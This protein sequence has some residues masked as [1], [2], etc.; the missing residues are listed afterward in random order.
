MKSNEGQIAILNPYEASKFCDEGIR[1]RFAI[2]EKILKNRSQ[3]HSVGTF[4]QELEDTIRLRFLQSLKNPGVRSAI[5]LRI[6][7][8]KLLVESSLAHCSNMSKLPI[9]EETKE[10]LIKLAQEIVILSYLSEFFR[11]CRYKV[12]DIPEPLLIV[13]E[14][15]GECGLII[16]GEII[17]SQIR[18][19]I[20][21]YL[22][23]SSS[24]I[25]A[26]EKEEVSTFEELV[27]IIYKDELKDAF[28][29]RFGINIR[30]AVK[31]TEYIARTAEGLKVEPLGRFK[32]VIER[33]LRIPE[34]KIKKVIEL[35]EC[36]K[37]YLESVFGEEKGHYKLFNNPF[38]LLRKPF[39]KLKHGGKRYIVYGPYTVLYALV[40]FLSDI[41]RG[42]I[43]L[44]EVS[45]KLREKYGKLFEQKLREILQKHGLTVLHPKKIPPGEIDALIYDEQK[46]LAVV[47]EAK[48]HRT[49]VS[50]RDLW[51]QI[52]KENE[53]WVKKLERKL[54]WI[55][56]HHR[57]L[58]LH[59]VEKVHGVIVT[60]GPLYAYTSEKDIEIITF[61]Q[62]PEVLEKVGINVPEAL[63]KELFLD[64]S[65]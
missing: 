11:Y 45:N 20:S 16:P 43:P 36:K 17:A 53:E 27:E 65:V 39:V 18:M 19:H 58:N 10:Q 37:E 62:L 26:I 7:A 63:K 2:L 3:F 34:N 24:K 56:Q 23:E 51:F 61:V 41:D 13:D 52:K 50:P 48:A 25:R 55:Q 38:S 31:F 21:A 32:R 4:Y 30:D 22:L 40:V 49:D 42:F 33:N 8:L 47:I 29:K 54:E 59:E 1:K 35:F 15:S 14:S 9:N 46:K 12:E 60:L 28:K 57:E 64:F 6:Y 44:G 5:A